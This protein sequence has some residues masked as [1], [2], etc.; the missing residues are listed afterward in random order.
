MSSETRDTAEGARNRLT[1]EARS[2]SGKGERP[3]QPMLDRRAVPG[4]KRL[5]AS[6]PL[7]GIDLERSRDP[8]RKVDF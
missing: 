5:L 4:F 1:G 8:G 6:A 7:D 3:E 2:G